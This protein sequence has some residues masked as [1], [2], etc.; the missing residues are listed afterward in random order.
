MAVDYN[1]TLDF[2]QKGESFDT[3]RDDLYEEA[4]V[5]LGARLAHAAIVLGS[6][7]VS[8]KVFSAIKL[9]GR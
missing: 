4:I 5:A 3:E 1:K 9:L 8:I 7:R 2:G 6:D